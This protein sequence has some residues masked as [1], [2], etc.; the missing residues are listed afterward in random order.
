MIELHRG[1]YHVFVFSVY[2]LCH[3][4]LVLVECS[5]G[6]PLVARKVDFT[7]V[8]LMVLHFFG[9]QVDIP[10]VIFMVLHFFCQKS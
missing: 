7:I 5:M 8:N 3:Y 6:F 1:S 9:Q 10:I 4:F 2:L